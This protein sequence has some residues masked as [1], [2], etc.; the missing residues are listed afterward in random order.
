[1][2]SNCPTLGRLKPGLHA[3]HRFELTVRFN[4]STFNVLTSLLNSSFNGE[5]I[6]DVAVGV[7]VID[8]FVCS[9]R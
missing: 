5:Q 3:F 2:R 9:A 4:D 7:K 8:T 1:M 6:L